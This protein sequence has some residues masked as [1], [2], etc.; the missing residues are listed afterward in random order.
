MQGKALWKYAE[1]LSV[2][3]E[4]FSALHY[5][6]SLLPWEGSS[7]GTDPS[8]VISILLPAQLSPKVWQTIFMIAL[9]KQR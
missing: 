7:V 6:T 4:R 2:K 1:G 3:Q 9:P 8:W 5:E